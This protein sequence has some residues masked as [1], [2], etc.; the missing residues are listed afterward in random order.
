MARPQ[1]PLIDELVDVFAAYERAGSSFLDLPRALVVPRIPEDRPNADFVEIPSQQSEQLVDDAR[2]FF[3]R[4]TGE[5]AVV[6]DSASSKEV[7]EL[8]RDRGL[9]DEFLTFRRELSR[10][11]I[12]EWLAEQGVIYT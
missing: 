6:S 4:K 8:L 2:V 5:K 9:E 3:E 11:R 12:Q 10:L 7:R 1:N